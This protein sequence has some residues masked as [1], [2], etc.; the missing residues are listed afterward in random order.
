[1]GVGATSFMV[2]YVQNVTAC[3]TRALNDQGP[4]GRFARGTL[5]QQL[6]FLV[7]MRTLEIRS[8]DR[9]LLNLTQHFH[10]ANQRSLMRSANLDI[11]FPPTFHT[12]ATRLQQVLAEMGYDPLQL[13]ESLPIPI[14]INLCLKRAGHHRFGRASLQRP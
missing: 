14:D 3:L 8:M 5:K 12:Q 1:M 2:D 9:K 7:G 6:E 13:G 10:L 11:E 4:L